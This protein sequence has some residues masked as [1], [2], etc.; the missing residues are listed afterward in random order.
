MAAYLL[1]PA[2]PLHKLTQQ[3][4][5]QQ[6]TQTEQLVVLQHLLT[7]E[8]PYRKLFETLAAPG[9]VPFHAVRQVR[10]CILLAECL[11]ACL[12]V[13]GLCSRWL[14]QETADGVNLEQHCVLQEGTRWRY[15]A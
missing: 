8:E 14:Q 7:V 10:C 11:E 15:W 5:Q 6:H 4:Q 9:P 2:G 12:R 3:Q 13:R 1:G